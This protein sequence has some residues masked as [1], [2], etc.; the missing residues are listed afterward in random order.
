MKTGITFEDF[1]HIFH[2]DMPPESAVQKLRLQLDSLVEYDEW[3]DEELIAGEYDGTG[4]DE[5]IDMVI[6]SASGYL[7]RRLLKRT[8]CD[9][10]RDSLLTNLSTSDLAVGEL[11]DERISSVL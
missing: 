9:V 8:K 10:C 3:D 4:S 1:K 6:Y 11:E 2:D 5:L 7:C